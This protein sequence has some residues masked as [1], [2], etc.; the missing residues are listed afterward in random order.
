MA[1]RR[2]P[3]VYTIPPHRAFA[4][5]LVAGILAQHA[6]DP[7]AL[8]RGIILLPNNRA[9]Q[10][11]SDAFVRK[12]EAGLLMPRLVPI[13][14]P[15]LDDRTGPA[16]DP[17]GEEPLPPAV[18]PL[19]R[20]LI[21]ARLLGDARVMDAAE[22]M[23]LAAELGRVLDQLLVEEKTVQDL[24][25]VE[26]AEGLSEHWEQA[27][28]LLMRVLNRW[29]DEL[30][31]L[32]AIDLADRRN[33]L[34][35]RVADRWA[36]E[37]APGFVVAAGI[38][39]G[40]P[41][42][43]RLLKTIARLPNGQVVLAGLD[44]HI[45]DEEWA[46]IG[47]EDPHPPIETHPQFHLRQML[48]RMG[49]AR[50]EVRLWRYGSE[51]DAPS[52]R[53]RAISN[54]LAP[55][56]FTDKWARLPAAEKRLSGVSAMEVA[57]PADEAQAVA[58]AIREAVSRPGTVA[59]VTPDRGLAR[60]V[61]THLARWGIAADDSAGRPLSATAPGMALLALAT[62][63]AEG[64]A[65]VPLLALLKHPLIC[66][67]EGR[68]A[69]LDGARALDLALRGPRPF[70]S[71]A[72]I[73]RFLDVGDDRTAKVRKVAR[74]W[75]EGV[76]PLLQPLEQ[77]CQGPAPL[78]DLLEALR[79]ALAAL[80]GDALWSGDAGRALADLFADL[81]GYAGDGPASVDPAVL[82]IL[83]R[84]LTDGTTCR[85]V[86]G[87]HP[88]V[89]I[90]GLL[91]AK[92]QSAD[93]MI[94]AGLNEGTWPALP[95]PDPWLAP[96]VRRALGLPSL[97]RRIG[98]S[99]HDLAG[100]LGAR[101]VLLSRARRD[102]GGP[103]NA[104]RFW[105]RLETMTGHLP[106]P[107]LRYDLLARAL[108]GSQRP[109]QRATRPSP[110]PPAKVRPRRIS[111]T[112]VDRLAADP[113]SYYAK[114][115]LKLYRL[116]PVDAEPGAAWKGTLIHDVLE[117]WAKQDGYAQGA[118]EARMRHALDGLGVHPVIRQLWLPR[119]IEASV[120]IERKVDEARAKGRKP[121]A[122]EVS[123]EAVCDGVTLQGRVDRI[124]RSAEGLAIIDY[125]TG[126]A[127]TDKQVREGFA[128]QLG[129]LGF[130]AEQGGF[131]GLAGKAVG[132]EY[133]SFERSKTGFGTISSPAGEDKKK[134]PT[135]EFVDRIVD[136]F[137]VAAARWL[138]GDEPFTAKLK[139]DYA[140]GDYDQ[141]MRLEEWQGRDA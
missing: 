46:A 81:Q 47:G 49:V 121:V 101:H 91:E 103:A 41:A 95:T 85:P 105:L 6:K 119:L 96:A 128:F 28:E 65:P 4:D 14:D 9:V 110:A 69:W 87:G 1:D 27:L 114:S 137:R 77:A 52:E 58:L 61:S 92:L 125:K 56:R 19:R 29:P 71:L 67:G 54:A 135:A 84:Q 88:R 24:M 79:T 73:T 97:E 78:A 112:D 70:A 5:A 7:L 123:G 2:D 25:T 138:T 40:A 30:A 39:T 94:L 26:L 35:H 111:V 59:L 34:L 99:A 109:P 76:L 75:W 12:A 134:I 93:L 98:L 21:F 133:W 42:V 117:Q 74:D 64:F 36:S 115:M 113:Y 89:F 13:G 33:R 51:G 130:I 18:D 38:S 44:T 140:Y 136:Q 129:L 11:L 68:L 53:S 60:R 16:L 100:A 102:M 43:A 122:S 116:D 15:E 72:G 120:W 3:A 45:P 127:P 8:A 131:D 124:D 86:R 37:G 107:A 83:L 104:S 132:F 31:K 106:E 32:G 20:Q 57:T 23:R 82:P 63:V 62:A 66:A 90:W 22:A 80:S 48:D 17:L 118:L 141:L 10:A 139:P 50:A 55:A 108:D 126:S